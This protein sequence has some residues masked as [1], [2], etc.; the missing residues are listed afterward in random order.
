MPITLGNTNITGLGVGTGIP[1]N[2]LSGRV[3][4]ANA[5]LGA[6]LQVVQFWTDATTL[7]SSTGSSGFQN[8]GVSASITPTATSSKIL[9]VYNVTLGMQSNAQSVVRLLRSGTVIGASNQS[10]G[11]R[12]IG[13]SVH[14]GGSNYSPQHQVGTSGMTFLDTP[15]TTSALTYSLQVRTRSDSNYR[16]RLNAADELNT[17]SYQTLGVSTITLYEIAG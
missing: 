1:A 16:V 10:A 14:T 7:I 13:S 9:V 17:F 4:A 3:P 15:N 5:N 12:I 8:L 2:T 11:S 6:V